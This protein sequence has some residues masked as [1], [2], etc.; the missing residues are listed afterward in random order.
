M[1]A[2]GLPITGFADP[3]TEYLGAPESL[4]SAIGMVIN[5]V[6]FAILAMW[7]L[8]GKEYVFP[9]KQPQNKTQ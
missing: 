3:I 9:R 1:H 6:G 4:V 7:V 2:I 8:D 5:L